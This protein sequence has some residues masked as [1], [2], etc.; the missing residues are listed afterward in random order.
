[1]ILASWNTRT[2]QYT[3]SSLPRKR[4]ALIASELARYDVDIAAMSE[5]R[6]TETGSLTESGEGYTFF[7]GKG[8]PQNRLGSMA[9]VLLHVTPS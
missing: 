1:M 5:T 6:V 8:Y 4:T 7:S 3:N 2:L 9:W